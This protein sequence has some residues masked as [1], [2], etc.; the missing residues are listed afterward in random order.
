MKSRYSFFQNR[1]ITHVHYKN[2]DHVHYK[3]LDRYEISDQNKI[4]A[5]VSFV[6]LL[7]GPLV[8]AITK[9]R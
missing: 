2:L 4:K 1:S 6:G 9:I 7:L 8:T 5:L 3:N